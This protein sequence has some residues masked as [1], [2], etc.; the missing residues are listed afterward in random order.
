M[1][2][3]MLHVK[4]KYKISNTIIRQRTKV[5]EIAEHVTNAKCK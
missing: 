3:K 2:R 4:L 1:E 5:T